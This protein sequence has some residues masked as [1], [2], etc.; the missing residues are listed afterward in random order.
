MGKNGRTSNLL[1]TYKYMIPLKN[2]SKEREIIPAGNYVAVL[3]SIVQIG[4]VPESYMGEEKMLAK[5]RFTWE[6]PKLQREFDGVMKPM[7]IGDDYTISWGEKANLRKVVQGILGETP[8]DEG[9]DLKSLLG[10]ACMLQVINGVGKASGRKYAAVGSV[11]QLPEEI[12]PPKQFNPSTYLDYQ[13]GWD[14]EV[15]TALPQFIKEKMAPSQEMKARAGA[16]YPG[17]EINPEDIPF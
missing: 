10:T 1:I 5:V 9:F 6:I 7:V 8:E 2:E 4:T 14:S 16:N 15:Y 12:T 13:E 11:A 17:Q 3:Y